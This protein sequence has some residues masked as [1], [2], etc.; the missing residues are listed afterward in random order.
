MRVLQ[1]SDLRTVCEWG[2]VDTAV[3]LLRLQPSD[4]QSVLGVADSRS[5]LQ[6]YDLRRPQPKGL[7]YVC[8]YTV[9]VEEV[10]N[11]Q[12]VGNYVGVFH[13]FEPNVSFWNLTEQKT[14]L[15]INIQ[16]QI[17]QLAEEFYDDDDVDDASLFDE[18]DDH[19]TSVSSVPFDDDHVLIYGT[20]AGCIFGMAVDVRAKIFSIPFAHETGAERRGRKDV[21]GVSLLPDG[22]LI[23]CYEGCGLTM[24]DFSPEHPPDRPPTRGQPK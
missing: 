20:R 18:D 22:K 21:L 17:K 6:V 8:L 14:I 11:F 7:G 3:S 12:L 4:T 13:R 15:C 24:L 23:A 5:G 9:P 1:I 10:R 19:V 2:A 16:E